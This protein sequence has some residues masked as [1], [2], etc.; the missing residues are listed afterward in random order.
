VQA[1][2]RCYVIRHPLPAATSHTAIGAAPPALRVDERIALEAA[3]ASARPVLLFWMLH[4]WVYHVQS[5][6]SY[7][8]S[9]DLVSVWI[10]LLCEWTSG[11]EA[12]GVQPRL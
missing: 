8:S 7:N 9:K 10:Y 6:L 1:F 3:A 12:Q 2:V 11:R 4:E 5:D